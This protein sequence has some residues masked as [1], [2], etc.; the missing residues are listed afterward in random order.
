MRE[1]PANPGSAPLM[2]GLVDRLPSLRPGWRTRL[3]RWE[4]RLRDRAAAWVLLFRSDDPASKRRRRIAG[5][6]GAACVVGAGVGGWLWLRPV[7]Q[8]DYALADLDDVFDF[9]LLTDEFNRLPVQDRLRLIGQLVQR[10][11][12]MK[13]NDSVLLAAFAAGIGGAAREQIEQ[14]ASRLA[15]DVW[16][17]YARD[18]A[19]VAQDQRAEYLEHVFVE[20]VKMREALQG[21][22]RD[23]PDEERIREGREEVQRDRERMRDPGRQ[24]DGQQLGRFFG[25][26]DGS[27][28]ARAS[29]AQRSRGLLM[30]RDMARHMR[31]QDIV[32]GRPLAAP[33]H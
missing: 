15:V 27:V 9:T 22:T 30:M 11:K 26:L 13:G 4:G 33:A 7:P 23:I 24:P 2:Q 19:A 6:V 25:F 31:G 28:G 21:E 8:P 10:L 16:D 20:F 18:Y 5:V 29:P 32:T 14:N 12:D 1:P 17:K 3:R